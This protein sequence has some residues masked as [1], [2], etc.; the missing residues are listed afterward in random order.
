MS[1]AFLSH[2]NELLLG[3]MAELRAWAEIRA[4][5][6]GIL[7]CERQQGHFQCLIEKQNKTKQELT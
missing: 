4:H 6:F 7:C 1:R 2:P 5:E 3:Q